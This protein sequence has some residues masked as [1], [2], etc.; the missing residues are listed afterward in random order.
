VRKLEA[1]EELCSSK[2][3]GASRVPETIDIIST[4]DHGDTAFTN[5]CPHRRDIGLKLEGIDGNNCDAR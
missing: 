1:A 3:D 5:L 2:D 4:S